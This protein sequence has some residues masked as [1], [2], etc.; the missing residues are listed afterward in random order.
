MRIAFCY[1][2]CRSSAIAFIAA[3]VCPIVVFYEWTEQ[4]TTASSYT[5]AANTLVL[6]LSIHRPHSDVYFQTV[7]FTFAFHRA[8]LVGKHGPMLTMLCLRIPSP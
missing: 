8:E 7:K 4:M 2:C 6:I 3:Y 5:T 1:S